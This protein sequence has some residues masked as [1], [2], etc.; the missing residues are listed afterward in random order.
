MTEQKE[1]SAKP[2][3]T[4]LMVTEQPEIIATDG[5]TT[6]V[7]KNDRRGTL[8]SALAI[9]IALAIGAGLWFINQQENQ[10][11]DTARHELG[12]KIAALQQQADRADSEK[13]SL[14]T[15]LKTQQQLL[16]KTVAQQA[17]LTRQLNA[18]NQKVV[19]I[20][21]NDASLWLLSQAD[22]LVKMAARKL[23]SDQDVATAIVLLKS[24]DSSLAEIND[25]GLIDIRRA[26]TQDM[27]DL[28]A[29]NQVDYDGIILR[30]NQLT[31]SVDDLRLADNNRDDAPMDENSSEISHSLHEWRQNLLK[32]WHKFM[33]DFITIRRRN[34]TAEP[35]LAPNQ[36]IY[37]RENIR[38][39]LLIATQAVP[40][41]QNEIFRQSIDTVSVWVRAWFDASDPATKAFLS[42]LDELHEQPVS[43][44]VPKSLHSQP[45]L[46]KLIQTRQSGLLAQPAGDVPSRAPD[47]QQGE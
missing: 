14:L 39:R 38:S 1:S 31:N 42:Q 20:S 44:E 24:A 13:Q 15:R 46:D 30:L 32:S 2:E 43:M 26:I 8:L 6:A 22:Y 12:A 41:H 37:L 10:Q 36:D 4:P 7:H 23:W 25:P 40:R 27:T 34:T 11:Q 47:L 35:L 28:A 5:A 9:V 29:I 19:T 21:G 18:L 16:D 17:A 33:D 3:E 45:L